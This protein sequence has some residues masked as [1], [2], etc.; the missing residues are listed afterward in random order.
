MIEN[1]AALGHFIWPK[2]RLQRLPRTIQDRGTLMFVIIVLCTTIGANVKCY[3]NSDFMSEACWSTSVN[4]RHWN[5]NHA[6][7]LR[8]KDN[9]MSMLNTSGW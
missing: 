6:S 2:H 1:F 9:V 8:F 7:V 5:V 3:Q 4:I